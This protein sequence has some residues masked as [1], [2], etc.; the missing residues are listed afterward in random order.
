MCFACGALATR[1]LVNRSLYVTLSSVWPKHSQQAKHM[2]RRGHSAWNAYTRS[3][4]GNGENDGHENAGHVLKFAGHKSAGYE[5]MKLA[6][7]RQ[8]FIVLF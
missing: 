2:Y 4:G 5:F 6:Q 8:T 7:K 1:A 3:D